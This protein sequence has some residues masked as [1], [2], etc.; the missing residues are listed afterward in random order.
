MNVPAPVYARRKTLKV[1]G[2]SSL[3]T[4]IPVGIGGCNRSQNSLELIAQQMISVLFYVEKAQKIGLLYISESPALQGQTYEQLT[5]LL[6]ERLQLSQGDITAEN[7]DLIDARMK[8]AVHRDFMDEDV[9]LL[10]GWM[11]SRTELILCALAAIFNSTLVA[12]IALKLR[13][14]NAE[15]IL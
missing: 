1:I 9:V 7:M 15:N 13:P 3:M 4:V 12:S 14:L 10:R 6:L 11:L 8:A 2:Y 5:E